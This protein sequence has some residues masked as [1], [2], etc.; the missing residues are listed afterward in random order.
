MRD[1]LARIVLAAALGC[2]SGS[3]CAVSAADPHPN[4][5]VVNGGKLPAETGGA[6]ALCQAVTAAVKA[7][8]PGRNYIVEIRVLGSSRLTASVTE[9][10]RKVAE[11][12]IA[13]MDKPLTAGSFKRFADAIAAELAKAGAGKS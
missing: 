4:C 5:H 12:S 11:Q 6:E 2:A 13:S 10:G 8:A 3:A 7:Q 9:D 1:K